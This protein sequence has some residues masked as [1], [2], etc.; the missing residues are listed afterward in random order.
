MVISV[1]VI[2]RA[3]NEK[4]PPAILHPKSLNLLHQRHT[5]MRSFLDCH[6][7]HLWKEMMLPQSTNSTAQN[8]AKNEQGFWALEWGRS[9]TGSWGEAGDSLRR[10]TRPKR[11]WSLSRVLQL[12]RWCRNWCWHSAVHSATPRPMARITSGWRWHSWRWRLTRPGTLSHITLEEPPAA[13]MYL[14][15]S[16]RKAKVLWT[17]LGGVLQETSTAWAWIPSPLLTLEGRGYFIFLPCR[18]RQGKH[19]QRPG[20]SYFQ[21][22]WWLAPE[23]G[24]TKGCFGP[25]GRGSSIV[26]IRA[27]RGAVCLGEHRKNFKEVSALSECHMSAFGFGGSWPLE[28]PQSH[29]F[30]LNVFTTASIYPISTCWDLRLHSSYKHAILSTLKNP[31]NGFIFYFSGTYRHFFFFGEKKNLSVVIKSTK[32]LEESA[33]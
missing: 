12:Q 4:A 29:L 17:E 3:K 21:T 6:N 32:Y 15:E 5:D 9:G 26:K 28:V 7:S 23:V 27:W 14:W 19:G 1:E 20:Q 24:A 2:D 30:D 11:L 33:L 10:R 22:E 8:A 25:G 18:S 13:L 31:E 16:K